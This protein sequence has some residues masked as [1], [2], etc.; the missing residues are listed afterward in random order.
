MATLL[1]IVA[2]ETAIVWPAGYLRDVPQLLRTVQIVAV[3]RMR[4]GD[5]ECAARKLN[6]PGRLA[7]R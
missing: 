7:R 3:V 1:E 6:L 5:I 2:I 4:D